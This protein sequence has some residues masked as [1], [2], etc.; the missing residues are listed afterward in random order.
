MRE[1]DFPFLEE[2]D[3]FAILFQPEETLISVGIV[4]T[5]ERCSLFIVNSRF[6]HDAFSPRVG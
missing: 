3:F 5:A 1:T 6:E 4:S 2:A